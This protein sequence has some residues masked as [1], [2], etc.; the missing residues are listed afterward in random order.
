MENLLKT[1]KIPDADQVEV[2]NIRLTD[3]ARTWWLAEEASLTPPVNWEMFSNGFF[4]RF[5]P[6]TARR[7]M[8]E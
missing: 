7:E 4:E 1:T 5:F 2:I 3:V 6:L 8:E